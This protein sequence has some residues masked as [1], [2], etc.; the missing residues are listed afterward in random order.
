MWWDNLQTPM[1]PSW[2]NTLPFLINTA[3]Q[4][5]IKFETRLSATLTKITVKVVQYLSKTDRP[6]VEVKPLH[7]GIPRPLSVLK[8]LPRSFGEKQKRCGATASITGDKSSSGCRGRC[9]FHHMHSKNDEMM[10]CWSSAQLTVNS[11]DSQKKLNDISRCS[12]VGA[13]IGRVDSL[14]IQPRRMTSRWRYDH[15]VYAPQEKEKKTFVNLVWHL[16]LWVNDLLQ[17]K[18]NIFNWQRLIIPKLCSYPKVESSHA[19]VSLV[20]IVDVQHHS[21]ESGPMLQPCRGTNSGYIVY[22]SAISY[23]CLH[24]TCTNT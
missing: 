19:C 3:C 6:L 10:S 5:G 17:K 15:F 9:S 11:T 20:R 7:N 22:I 18:N 1:G 24:V 4:T 8:S 12:W 23:Y 16:L 2:E 21:T 14:Q 13:S